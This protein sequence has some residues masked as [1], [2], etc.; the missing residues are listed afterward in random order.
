MKKPAH[1][2]PVA[3]TKPEA[4]EKDEA[5]EAVEFDGSIEG[6]VDV[7]EEPLPGRRERVSHS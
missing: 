3:V 6:G 5:A 7:D 1:K 4:H 2:M